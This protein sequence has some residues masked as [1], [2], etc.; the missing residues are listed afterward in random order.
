MIELE[1]VCHRLETLPGR[2]VDVLHDVSLRIVEGEYIALMGANGSGKST[3]ARHLN[4]LL[5][6][7]RGSVRVDGIDT[8]DHARLWDIRQ[9]VGLVFQNPDH[10]MVAPVVE[11]EVAFGPENLGL[12]I[13]EIRA[14]VEDALGAVDMLAFRR[15]NP[16]NLSGGQKQRIAIA[17]MLA[18]RPR[19]LVLDEPTAM[20]DA[21]GR[22]EVLSILRRLHREQAMTVVL[23]THSMEEAAES[24][25]VLVLQGG[26]VAADGPLSQVAADPQA[27]RRLGLPFPPMVAVLKVFIEAGFPLASPFPLEP[28]DAARA[29]VESFKAAPRRF[30]TGSP[31][32]AVVSR[33]L[34]HERPLVTGGEVEVM[35][36]DVWFRYL[37]GTPF[38]SLALQG[39]SASFRRGERVAVVGGTGSGKSSLL[40]HLN[41]LLRPDQG[42][43]L[44]GEHDLSERRPNLMEVRRRVGLMF[45]F[46]EHQLFEETVVADVGYGPRNLGMGPDEVDLR[47]RQALERV[48]LPLSEYGERSP[49]ALSGGEMRRVAM[50]GVLAMEPRVLVM[51]EPMAGLD[52]AGQDLLVGILSS[53]H[54]R[55]TTTVVVTHDLERVADVSDRTLVMEGGR[56]VHDGPLEGAMTGDGATS[57]DLVTP[58]AC[59]RLARALCTLGL[60]VDPSAVRPRVLAQEVGKA[61]MNQGQA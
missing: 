22:C 34:H 42:R 18:M 30:A 1:N 58:P 36:D 26:R 57:A 43:V 21:R 46:P 25:R 11:E 38:E 41:G 45:Q 39:V 53:L 47:V 9:R 6:P 14:R 20:L 5:L 55:G 52:A 28:D 44:V 3:L 12:P 59:T 33:C 4:A 37:R 49:L 13:D 24:E 17:S 7:T 32:A 8:R 29:L 60:S 35:V 23:V 19:C 54:A 51:D 31:E 10:Q 16:G 15:H 50:A 56:I 27:V 61:L 48:G 40:Q 2:E